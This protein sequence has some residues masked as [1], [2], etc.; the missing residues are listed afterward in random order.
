MRAN[1]LRTKS[2]GVKKSG[3]QNILHSRYSR[4]ADLFLR[5]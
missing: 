2:Q 1:R 3:Q 5:Y 4:H